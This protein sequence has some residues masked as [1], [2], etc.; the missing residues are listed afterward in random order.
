MEPYNQYRSLYKA[1]SV[2]DIDR[3][4]NITTPA[5]GTIMKDM[6]GSGALRVAKSIGTSNRILKDAAGKKS[7]GGMAQEAFGN[8]TKGL[9][10]GRGWTSIAAGAVILAGVGLGMKKPGNIIV[11]AQESSNEAS[12][13]VVQPR[14]Q[15]TS[16]VVTQGQFDVRIKVR[17]AQKV[18]RSKFVDLGQVI[19]GKYKS[20]SKVQVNLKDDTDDINYKRI[21]DDAYRRAMVQGRG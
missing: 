17:D 1:R 3:A 8:F 10:E 5:E 6:A 9:R 15:S 13:P 2:Q 19:S 4:L 14:R 12:A 18:D 7:I 20:P 11:Q 16:R 21:F